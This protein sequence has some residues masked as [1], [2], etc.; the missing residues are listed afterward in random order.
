MQYVPDVPAVGL[1]DLTV[2]SKELISNAIQASDVEPLEPMVFHE[3]GPRVGFQEAALKAQALLRGNFS[4]DE[5][6]NTP[7]N[8]EIGDHVTMSVWCKI[9]N[10]RIARASTRMLNILGRFNALGGVKADDRLI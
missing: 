10:L 6:A 5:W 7:C 4:A 8:W 1:R 2:E 3:A 9:Q